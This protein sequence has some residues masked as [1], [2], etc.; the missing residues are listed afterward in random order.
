VWADGDDWSDSIPFGIGYVQFVDLR[1][2]AYA[3]GLDELLQVLNPEVETEADLLPFE[4]Q[5]TIPEDF[6]PRNPYKGLRAFRVEDRGDFFGRNAL[7]SE[8]VHALDFQ[9]HQPRFLALVG[10]SGSGKSSVIMAGLLPALMDGGLGDSAGWL[11]LEPMVPGAHPLENL[12]NELVKHLPDRGVFSVLDDLMHPSQRG[13]LL[14]AKQMV[15]GNQSVVLYIDQF[16]ELFS[17]VDDENERRQFI[18]VLI[19]AANEPESPLVI[20]ITLRADFYDRP[21]Q[22][23]DLG[24]LMDAHS[25]SVLPMSLADLYDVVQHPAALSDVRLSFE[26]DLVTQILFEIRGETSALPLLQ[27]T[28]DQ[29]FQRRDGQLLTRAAYDAMDGVQ[30]A[31]SQH[32]EATFNSLPS[33]RHK[34]LARSLFLRLIEL[35]YTEQ[36]ATRRRASLT[37]LILLDPEETAILQETARHFVDARLLVTAFQEDQNTIE[38]GHETLIRQWHRLSEWLLDA[39]EDFRLQR[40]LANDAAEWL[41]RNRSDDLLYRG[42]ILAEATRWAENNTPSR[43]EANFMQA[44]SAFEEA[45]EDERLRTA[46]RLR[47][48]LILVAAVIVTALITVII[49]FSR[50]N[51]DLQSEAATLTA[52]VGQ[53]QIEL[54]QAAN[55]VT[56]AVRR[57]ANV[58]STLSPIPPT[59]TRAADDIATANSRVDVANATLTPIPLTVEAAQAAAAAAGTELAAANLQVRA[60]NEQVQSANTQVAVANEDAQVAVVTARA[61]QATAEANVQTAQTHVAD[62]DAAAMNAQATANAAATIAQ[63]EIQSANTQIA[64][65]NAQAQTAGTQVRVAN[66]QATAAAIEVDTANATL[67]PIIPTLTQAAHDVDKAKA[68]AA[69]N[70]TEAAAAR[71]EAATAEFNVAYAQAQ[72]DWVRDR[73]LGNNDLPDVQITTTPATEFL[74]TATAVAA[75]TQLQVTEQDFDGIPMVYVPAGC[76]WMGGLGVGALLEGSALGNYDEPSLPIHEICF[77]TPFWIDKFE[78]TNGYWADFAGQNANRESANADANLPVVNV[79]WFDAQAY[80]AARGGRLPTEA[81]WEYAARGPRSLKYPWGNEF[82]INLV[83]ASMTIENGNSVNLDSPSQVGSR[84]GGQSWVGAYDMSGNVW[85]WVSTIPFPYPYTKD[86]G[87]EDLS[88]TNVERV[89]RGGSYAQS[90]IRTMT[91]IRTT[92]AAGEPHVT[93]GFRCARDAS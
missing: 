14:T 56:T 39:R 47:R 64:D 11:Y 37:E 19:T 84:E 52:E 28:L 75:L 36:E 86:D 1:G 23:P 12:A 17:R 81:E 15:D 68:E 49:I 9:P 78:V 29:L 6:V 18:E 70:A 40:T 93:V 85:E 66:G 38:I 42:A 62:A 76:F 74:A 10:A 24:R 21:L 67:T 2:S 65:A 83:V 45:Q 16:E 44:S 63:I 51:A 30:G 58:N 41:R 27:F 92:A 35:G 55:D 46:Q 8:L 33:P 4:D 54:Q 60:A 87:R 69:F 53:A 7:I 57:V 31:L 91:Y 90:F 48:L 89:V 72:G 71:E 80:C 3:Q 26:D 13:L 88:Q 77:D 61:V 82:D 5:P 50:N 20:I 43:D 73:V 25:I 22:Y 32:A 34:A 59:L 79:T